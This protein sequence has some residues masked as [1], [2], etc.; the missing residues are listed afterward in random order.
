[1]FVQALEKNKIYNWLI[2]IILFFVGMCYELRMMYIVSFLLII[3]FCFFYF[4]N[5]KRYWKIFIAGV[6][7][8]LLL[9]IFW[10][11][12]TV[13]GGG[14]AKIHNITSRHLFGSSFFTL[15]YAFNTYFSAW[16]GEEVTPFVNHPIMGY[17]WLIPIVAFIVFLS[18]KIRYRKIIIYFGVLSLLGI[19]L[20]K[21][22]AEPLPGVYLWLYKNF[23][24]FS[25]FREASKFYLISA[26]GYTGL[27]ACSLLMIK[28]NANV[29]VHRYL[30]IIFS[31]A[32]LLI[33]IINAKPLIT[34]EIRT[35]F[36]SKN[37]PGDYLVLK[38]YLINQ[39]DYFRT[40]WTP[41]CSTWGFYINNHP[42]VSNVGIIDS[43][44]KEFGDSMG[45]AKLTIQNKIVGILNHSF[46]DELF[47]VSSIKYVVVPL[48]DFAND[49][50]FYIYYGE[51][52]RS[53]IRAW[54]I[55]ELNQ[56]PWL[57]K[58][59]IGTSG[60]VVYENTN[61]KSHIY[62]DSGLNYYQ[63]NAS[64]FGDFSQNQNLYLNSE[65]KKHEDLLSNL[66]NVIVPVEAD[67]SKISAMQAKITTATTTKDSRALQSALDMYARNLFFSDYKINIPLKAVYKI[68]IKEDSTL[69]NNKN[70]GVKI[71]NRI[72]LRKEG[73]DK[74]GW[75]YYNK[76]ELDQGE[77]PV[78]IYLG[79]QLLSAINSGDVV[80][81]AEDLR[82]PIQAPK[83]EYRQISPTKYIV[84][85]HGAS[86]SFPLIFSESFHQG[87]KI[88]VQPNLAEKES[89]KFVGEENQGTTQNENLNGGNFYDIF[90]RQP[91]LDDKHF[92]INNF[93]NAWWVD[94]DNL[95]KAGKIKKNSDNNYDFSVVIEFEPQKYFYIGL[96]IS[97]LALL[98]CL[99]CL[100]GCI[101]YK[102]RRKR[103]NKINIK[104]EAR[105]AQTKV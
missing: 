6:A 63:T 64:E 4:K 76:I 84:N 49:N 35:M 38:D 82:E 42:K 58:I 11:L 12:P 29:I 5:I 71:N 30:F 8:L 91:V 51:S 68:Y 77:Y 45:D 39:P 78:E 66:D 96:G 59:D 99:G 16:T 33:S 54:Y 53:D 102:F 21:Q 73:K 50:D 95:A 79:N 52:D 105:E 60:L 62:T 10:L 24:G 86:E 37:M 100:A 103:Y 65:I 93:A 81:S 47:D 101:F 34:G 22:S 89:G 90:S 57:K 69:A 23:P 85:V 32:I 83:L 27:I 92:Q 14:A 40:F 97:I 25:L 56:I 19:F 36:I 3:Y 55:S 46:S 43:G 15:S 75:L 67:Q 18:K 94:L 26:I 20:T 87:W 104:N 44:W 41:S 2:F 17:F 31:A 74:D 61:F 9:N 70:I 72:L 98:M 88:Y 80:F 28:E 13:F 48:Q 7:A 1:M